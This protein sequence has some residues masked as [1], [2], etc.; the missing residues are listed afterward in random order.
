MNNKAKWIPWLIALV[1]ISVGANLYYITR[2][3]DGQEGAAQAAKEQYVCPMHPQVV[4][5]HA[6]D[7]PICGMKLVKRSTVSMDAETDSL[8]ASVHLSPSQE[9]LAN[10]RTAHPQVQ[11]FA[12]MR[13]LPGRIVAKEDAQWKAS[14]RVMG[15]IN[16]LYVAT[17][18]Q[19]VSKGQPIYDLF[20]PDLSNAQRE[21]ILAKQ[22][23]D[24]QTRELLTGAAR[25]KLLSLGMAEAQIAALETTAE[26]RDVLT[27]RA[28][29]PG[30]LME[31]MIS[32]G[33]WVM[34]G[35]VMLEFADL[36]DVWVEGTIYERDLGSVKIGDHV[37][38]TTPD[39]S[40]SR[41]TATVSFVSPMLD[42]MS[43]TQVIRA[44]LANSDLRW[45]PEMFVQVSWEG[46]D[47]QAALA[48]PDDA[49]LSTG[50]S[51]RV[52]VK[53]AEGRYQPRDVVV[54]A[55]HDGQ[56]AIL[57]G[58]AASDEVVVSGGYLIDSDAQMKSIGT[59]HQHEPQTAEPEAVDP[60]AG[61][62]SSS[63]NA[64]PKTNEQS[65][66]F[67]TMCPEITSDKPGRC[68]NCGM[69]LVEREG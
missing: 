34:P 51:N 17:P 9:V 47:A 3:H 26:T 59:G 46:Q 1:V 15:R 33:E 50:R 35:M 38:I 27:F 69:K 49:V 55:R 29:S 2:H 42:M 18:G 12:A 23:S 10:V 4:S 53:V 66:Y 40:H 13:T 25:G 8:A 65:K 19:Y 45:K 57:S 54:G 68:S 24:A 31:K 52:W 36:T 5:D 16:R 62:K 60:H 7:C 37:S 30:V 14:A 43:R 32:E 61:H 63:M 28:P 48:V 58:V 39:N 21:Y 67:C 41:T 11:T 56:I 22:S 44:T 6:A 64:P 20:S